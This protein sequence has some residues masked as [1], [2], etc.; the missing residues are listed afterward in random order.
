MSILKKILGKN[1]SENEQESLDDISDTSDSDEVIESV[2]D[3]NKRLVSSPFTNEK[4]NKMLSG[5]E[6]TRTF[7]TSNWP[8][9]PNDQ[10]LKNVINRPPVQ[11]D[12]SIYIDPK[13]EDSTIRRLKKRR[14]TLRREIGTDADV[15]AERDRK[16]KL[17]KIEAI[18]NL[19]TDTETSIF[20]VSMY[21][22]VRSSEDQLDEDSRKIR[23]ELE[24]APVFTSQEVPSYAQD[25]ALKSVS[26]VSKNV[27]GEN[28]TFKTDTTMMSGAVAAMLPFTSRTLIEP[29]GV[30][31][32]IQAENSSPVIVDRWGR[33]NGYNQLTIGT[34][35]SGKSFSTKLNILRTYAAYDDVIIFMLDPLLGFKG[36][37]EH[38][39]GEQIPVGGGK[40]LN[41]LD[42]KAPN[43]IEDINL[44]DIDG[45]PYKQKLKTVNGFIR[46]FMKE[47]EKEIG[48][49]MDIISK[50]VNLAYQRNGIKPNDI[51][52]HANE[53]PTMLDVLEILREMS[54]DGEKF[55]NVVESDEP[56]RIEELATTARLRLQDFQEGREFSYLAGETEIDLHG[57]DVIYLDLSQQESSG[58]SGL[59]M[60][61]L[62]EQVYQRAK[63]TDKRVLFCIDEAHYMMDEDDDLEFLSQAVRH[64]RHYDMSINFISQT[65]REFLVN[66]QAKDIADNCVIKLLQ[67]TK[68]LHPEPAETLGLNGPETSFVRNAQEGDPEMGYSE[69]LLGVEGE[70]MPIQV[71]ASE[72]EE[73]LVTLSPEEI[74]EE[75]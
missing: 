22:T 52:S 69:A 27:L 25:E 5:G 72:V 53:S 68:D 20:D 16:K 3:I 46:N 49:E 12:M 39:N 48:P 59:M 36:I 45:S 58:T 26:P 73:M 37:C 51:E 66:E 75:L 33:G 65:A 57:N 40:T 28:E 11:N 15:V 7:F 44:D 30:E 1:D 55:A 24:S 70:F 56:E 38:L 62:F 64:S 18:I 9:E 42:I 61:I 6:W 35:G 54:A 60:K 67:R 50:A 19:L 13:D 47:T 74:A 23:Q 34:I 17:E 2:D 71:H 29:E 14:A 41:P 63:Q 43:N 32:G 4:R 8:D 21:T 10:F 31:M